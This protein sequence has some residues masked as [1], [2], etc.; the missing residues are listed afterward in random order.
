MYTNVRKYRLLETF[1]LKKKK[2]VIM[3]YVNDL[4]TQS[5]DLFMCTS[6]FAQASKRPV[7]G[8]S[9]STLKTLCGV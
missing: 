7:S 6:V 2:A 4:M 5:S 8:S 1:V 3:F 9:W